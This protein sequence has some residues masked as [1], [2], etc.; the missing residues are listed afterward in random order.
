MTPSP[1]INRLALAGLAAMAAALP[2]A[3]AAQAKPVPPPVP[4]KIQVPAGN[5]VSLKRHAIGVQIYTCSSTA[6]GHSWGSSVPRADLYNERG[7]LRGTHYAGPTWLDHDGSK[8]VASRVDG[9]TVDPTAIPWLLLKANP[10]SGSDPGKLAGTT[11]VQR[12]AT[13]GGL[14][15]AAGDCNAATVGTV[16]QVPY[17]ADYYFWKAAGH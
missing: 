13:T 12:V 5:K 10:D 11:Y 8:V 2:A 16:A 1:R 6:T 17:T 15:P 3:Q 7:K 4:T 14:P 9:V